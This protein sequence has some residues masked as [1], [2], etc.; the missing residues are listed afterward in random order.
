MCAGSGRCRMAC[1]TAGCGT[2]GWGS[3]SSYT[4]CIVTG[5]CT[6]RGI[7]A[8]C[9]LGD[10]GS[11]Q[12]NINGIIEVICTDISAGHCAGMA[13]TAGDTTQS[14]V[15]GMCAGNHSSCCSTVAG[16]AGSRNVPYRCYQWSAGCRRV[17]DSVVTCSVPIA[18]GTGTALRVLN[19]EA[20][21]HVDKSVNVRRLSH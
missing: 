21:G 13:G 14:S 2:P 11:V 5:C 7:H 15:L 9:V 10:T 17:A 3:C 6:G 1:G 18:A 4:V 19:I 20:T 8:W 16:I 12:G